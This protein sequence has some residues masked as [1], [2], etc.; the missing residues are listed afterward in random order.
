MLA[1]RGGSALVITSQLGQRII[2]VSFE[3]FQMFVV[4]S[5]FAVQISH[6]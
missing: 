6:L 1:N 3:P 2:G 4:G 5:R